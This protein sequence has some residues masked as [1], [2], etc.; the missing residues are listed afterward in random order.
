LARQPE[1]LWDESLPV[2]VRGVPPSRAVI[3]HPL[4]TVAFPPNDPPTTGEPVVG[5]AKGTSRGLHDAVL[6]EGDSESAVAVRPVRVLV[7][8]R[9]GLDAAVRPVL[10]GGAGRRAIVPLP[11]EVVRRTEDRERRVEL[12]TGVLGRDLDRRPVRRRPG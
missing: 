4:S 7:G 1:S 5:P 10:D 6:G 2:E 3:S 9:L 11:L 12:W 8:V